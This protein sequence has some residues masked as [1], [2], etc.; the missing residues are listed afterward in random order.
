[1]RGFKAELERDIKLEEQLLERYEKELAASPRGSLTRYCKG[2][3]TY[4]KHVFYVTEG[5]EKKVMKVERH[6]RREDE[7]LFYAL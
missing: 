1:M 5:H 7:A 6:L 3:K 4:Y 2:R